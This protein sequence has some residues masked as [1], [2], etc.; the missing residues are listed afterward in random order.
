MTIAID[1][2]PGVGW[3][4]A[5]DAPTIAW[6]EWER[7]HFAAVVR[8]TIS[9]MQNPQSLN[10]HAISTSR[11]NYGWRGMVNKGSKHVTIREREK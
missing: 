7:R 11:D 8:S 1:W 5:P 4:P 6:A 3:P 10:S 9:G 2:I